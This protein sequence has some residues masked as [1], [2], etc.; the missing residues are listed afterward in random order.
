MLKKKTKLAPEPPNFLDVETFLTQI[1]E[2]ISVWKC[3]Q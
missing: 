1:P 2:V 3:F